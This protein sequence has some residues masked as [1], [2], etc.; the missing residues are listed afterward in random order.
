MTPTKTININGFEVPE[1]LREA[2]TLECQIYFPLISSPAFYDCFFFTNTP[3]QEKLILRGICHL[4]KE[5]ANL[6]AKALLSFTTLGK[7]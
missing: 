5:A 7:E 3:W 4:T 2:P 6:H 1:P